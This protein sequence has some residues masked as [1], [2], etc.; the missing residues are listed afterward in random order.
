LQAIDAN[1]RPKKRRD[2]YENHFHRESFSSMN[3]GLASANSLF[4]MDF[5]LEEGQSVAS[6][7]NRSTTPFASL[8]FKNRNPESNGALSTKDGDDAFAPLGLQR[9]VHSFGSLGLCLDGPSASMEE[10]WRDL[11]TPPATVPAAFSPPPLAPRH[12]HD[13]PFQATPTKRIQG[14]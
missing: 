12:V 9:S 6:S 2:S 1:R 14:L 13:E 5:Y 10:H 11:V 8:S 3:S 4:G 7:T